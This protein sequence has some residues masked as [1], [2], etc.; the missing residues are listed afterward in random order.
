MAAGT[1]NS[2]SPSRASS[3]GSAQERDV[4]LVRGVE[5][6]SREGEPTGQGFAALDE[7]ASVLGALHGEY[8][9]S[10]LHGTDIG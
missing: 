2:S 8:G 9:R 6:R 4:L 5:S 10:L 7:E 3:F 1:V